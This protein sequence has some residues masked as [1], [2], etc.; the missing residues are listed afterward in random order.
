MVELCADVPLGVAHVLRRSYGG[1]VLNSLIAAARLGGRCGFISRVGND[2]FGAAMRQSWSDEGIDVSHSPLVPGD[3]GVYFISV[4]DAGD[5]EFSYRRK[6]SPASHLAA[7]EL[8]E[9]YIASSEMLLLS[10]ITQALSASA[11]ESTLVAAQIAK[12]HGVKVAFDP[13]YRS[14]LWATQGG[15]NAARDAMRELAPFVDW[16]LPSHPADTVLLSDH[17][18]ELPIDDFAGSAESLQGF[19]ALC[20]QVALKVGAR[21][22]RLHT[23]IAST[24]VDGVKAAKVIDSTGAGDLWNGSFLIAVI[25]GE[26]PVNAATAAHHLAASKLAYRGAIPPLSLYGSSR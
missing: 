3:N 9:S 8:S 19:S 2:P 22:C 7:S 11:R 12:R 17:A 4:D 1:D 10:G 5:R 6:D 24:H 20:P 14:R 23:P 26:T 15:L 25:R 21:G 13:N 18:S 16:L